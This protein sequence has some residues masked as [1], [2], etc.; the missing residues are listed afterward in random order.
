MKEY[1]IR[2]NGTLRIQT[3]NEEPSLA[4]QQFKEE[5]DVSYIM[6]KYE[7]TGQLFHVNRKQGVYADLS[8]L[9]DYR[10]MLAD[11]Q[12]AE[13]AF[14]SLPAKVR[15][16]FGNDPSKL[17]TFLQDTNNKQKAIELGLIDK[18]NDDL[19]T[20]ITPDDPSKK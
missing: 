6:K 19:T 12:K 1:T 5:C 15:Y 14:E 7:Q 10:Q 11:V 9:T 8:E 17:I 20:I 13:E 16:E 4:Q 3:I 2:P 18:T